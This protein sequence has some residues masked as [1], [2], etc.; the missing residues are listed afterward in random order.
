MFISGENL[1]GAQSSMDCKK[2]QP[3]CCSEANS[4]CLQVTHKEIEKNIS[5]TF[6]NHSSKR[7][8]L[9]LETYRTLGKR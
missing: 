8:N 2:T 3:N 6:G 7:A 9:K 4:Q 1:A 5:A